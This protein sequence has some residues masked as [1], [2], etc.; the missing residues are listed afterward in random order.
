MSFRARLT[1]FFLLIV[2]VPMAATG[3]L[4]FRL[5]SDSQQAK[6][7][8]RVTGLASAAASLYGQASRSASLD[9]RAV[10]RRLEAVPVGQLAARASALQSQ[11]GIERITVSVGGR[12]VADA[13]ASG[14]LAPGVASVRASAPSRSRSVTVSELSAA[15]FASQLS[16]RGFG[17]VVRQGNQTLSTTVGAAR[18]AVLPRSGTVSLGGQSYQVITLRLSGFGGTPV[19]VMVLSDASATNGSVAGDRV[20]AAIFILGFLILAFGFSFLASRGLQGQLASFLAAARRLARGDFSSPIP[21]QGNDEF[22]ALATEFNTMSAQLAARL[23]ELER[24]QARV[25]RS[26]R[27]IGDAFANN[28]DRDALLELALR[29]AMDATGADRGRVSG[30]GEA[31]DELTELVRR[32]RLT[33]LETLIGDSERGALEGDGIGQALSKELAMASVALGAVASGGPP[34]GLITVGRPGPSFNEDDLELLRSLAARATLA[35][36]NVNLHHDVQ[37]QAVTDDL[38]GLTT[39]GRFQQLLGTEMEQVRRYRYPVGLVMLDIDDFKSINDVYGH[40][41]GDVVLRAV[42]DVLRDNSRDVDLAARYGGEEMALILPHTD[43]EGTYVIAERTRRAIAAL[44]IPFLDRAGAL[45]ITASVGAAASVDGHKD[46]L[47][48]AADNALYVAKREG[49]N[50]TVKADSQTANVLGGR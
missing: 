28:L 6:A 26:I 3:F 12:L 41:Q 16:G 14:A 44:Q 5:I 37:R 40:P 33:E 17:V 42:A 48:T 49:K 18:N 8:A 9:A 7:E 25:R 38:T 19:R 15:Q 45:Q 22:A 30:R 21:T 50:R 36:A 34:H 4:V 27:T 47:I 43:L 24:E 31:G 13:G 46:E 32:G 29:T 10:A 20:V 11:V 23:Q 2:V 35:L 1:T 39:H